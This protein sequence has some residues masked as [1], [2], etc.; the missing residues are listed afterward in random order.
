MI[1]S[2]VVSIMALFHLNFGFEGC[3]PW[4]SQQYV[5]VAYI[6]DEELHDLVLLFSGDF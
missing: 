3:E 6:G 2:A 5:L 4:V 1:G